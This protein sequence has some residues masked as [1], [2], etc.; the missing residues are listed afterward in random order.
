MSVLHSQPEVSS[1]GSEERRPAQGL[2]CERPLGTGTCFLLLLRGGR[3]AAVKSG[4]KTLVPVNACTSFP[5]KWG[6]SYGTPNSPIRSSRTAWVRTNPVP[7]C[8]WELE[9][10]GPTQG[11]LRSRGGMLLTRAVT[12]D[13]WP[14]ST[15]NCKV[16]S[17]AGSWPE[18]M[19]ESAHKAVSDMDLPDTGANSHLCKR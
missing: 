5:F 13:G 14:L 10:P 7:T 4:I 2:Y 9:N 11:P 12:P 15:F 8:A 19:L 6:T 18:A 17:T 3:V 16:H 1:V